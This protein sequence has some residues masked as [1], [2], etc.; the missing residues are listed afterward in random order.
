[1][2]PFPYWWTAGKIA[3]REV[4][5]APGRFLF[6]ALSVAAGIAAVSGV[7]GSSDA[8]QATVRRN[9]RQWIAADVS[10]RVHESPDAAQSAVLEE[11][12]RRG[13]ASTTVT[14]TIAMAA[15]A[16]G[17]PPQ[18][19]ALKAVD[20]KVYPFYG[21]LAL[22]GG[23]PLRRV[24]AGDAVVV[25]EDLPRR[26]GSAAGGTLRVAGQEF[27]IAGVIAAEPDRFVTLPNP[28]PRVIL[29]R[30]AL[31]RSGLLGFGGRAAHRILF[32]LPDPRQVA[33]VRAEIERAFPEAKVLDFREPDPT[34]ARIVELAT[35][36]L[37]LVSLMALLVGALG[38]AVAIHAHLEQRLDSIAVMKSLGARS[39]QVLRIYV[40]QT[41]G[42]G[43]AGSLLG[44]GLGAVA[45]QA[46]PRLIPAYALVGAALE[47]RWD[48][49]AAS[50][51][52]GLAA[53]LLCALPP[54]LRIRTVPPALVLRREMRE[55]GSG[56]ARSWMRSPAA[57]GAGLAAGAA[58]GAVAAWL[59]GSWRM[60]G[61]FAAALG[62]G[63]AGLAAAGWLLLR[64]L[65]GLLGRASRGLSPAWRHGIANVYLP[66]NHARAV[67]VALGLG[68]MFPFATWLL[69]ASLVRDVLRRSPAGSGNL[70]LLN[71]GAG[72]RAAIAARLAALGGVLEAPQF[73]PLAVL[74]LQTVNGVP[75]E[76]SGARRM[77]YATYA[78]QP[79]A[80][81]QVLR[82]RWWAADDPAPQASLSEETARLMG[83][84]PGAA[85]EF[86]AGGKTVRAR[87]ACVHRLAGPAA[88]PYNLTLNRSAAA[89]L[90][91][92]YNAALHVAPER[93]DAVE[94]ALFRDFPE[95][96]S[97]N[98]AG[99][100]A[101]LE[102]FVDQIA[103]VVEF[104]ALFPIAAGVLI[105]ASS[106]AG[107]RFERTREIAVLKTLGATPR[108]VT[109]IFLLEFV[110]LG[111]AAGG[112]GV[113]L[114]GLF[115]DFLLRRLT[116]EALRL[117]WGA[118]LAAVAGAVLIANAAGWLAGA[119]L[120]RLRPLEIL[121]E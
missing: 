39:A 3:W 55:A 116:E 58:L 68:V 87:V 102:S 71:I 57:L 117:P 1:M 121:R 45:Q 35:A 113:L 24:L 50:L 28:L 6:V 17:G 60:A 119:R 14:E 74:T 78:D 90:P 33:D 51:A 42:L 81:M 82:G 83:A 52:T 95:V 15:A 9:L 20:P 110:I 70:L 88:L 111:G 61:W 84:A 105:L 40:L 31:E 27:R 5:A 80:G 86:V 103:A 66:G 46:A 22:R 120:L 64:A 49:V 94:E 41:A 56:R 25:S 53:T 47:W 79:A 97:M 62:A 65:R 77:W 109:A 30:E 37:S 108:R 10:A 118:A 85:L 54:L 104:L 100:A 69:Q 4:H 89:G 92:I 16:G 99:A 32:R 106:V 115:A 44:I 93:L 63:T 101:L 43:L 18:A 26:L 2:R 12:A 8:F 34:L 96:A 75:V 59:S 112:I 72:R 7:R 19:V 21:A 29:T 73:F 114:G 36:F 48:A 91:L 67:L 23:I 38:V 98:L 107:T 13:V 11:L 76:K